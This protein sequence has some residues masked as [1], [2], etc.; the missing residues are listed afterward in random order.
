[1]SDGGSG[2]IVSGCDASVDSDGDGI[3]DDLEGTEDLDGDGTPNHL[4]TDSDGD[5]IDDATEAGDSPCALR[6]TD[7]DGTADWWD[8]DSDNDG[9]SDAD[10][11]GTYGTDPRNIDSDMDGVTDLGEV[12]GTMTDPLDPSSTIPADDFFVVLPW[13]GPRENRLLRF[14]TDIS[15]ADIYFLIDTTGSMGSP[16]SNVQ[17]SLSMLVSEIATRIPNA[18][19]GVGQFRDLPLGG[20]LT[21]Y[22]SP[23]DMAYA[24]EQDI[25]DNTGAVQ[26]AL[27]GLVAGGGAD[28]PESHVL[29]LFQT[30]Q[31][32]GG[33][34]S[35]GSD[36]WSLAAKNCT[37]IPDEM[38]RRRGYPCFRPG[39]LPI[40]VMVTDVDMHNDPTGQDAYTGITPPPYS[41]DQAMSALGSIG[42]RF[43]GVAVNGG[44]R[45]DM[46]EV[47]RRTGTVDGSGAPLVFDA[48][49]GTVSNSIVDGIGTL[50]GGVAQDVGTRTENVP[51]NPDEFDATQ[52]I[53]AITPVE[54]Y[55]EGV[56]GTGYDSFDETTFY[57]VIPGTQVEFDVDFYNDV[58]PPAA[59]AEIF[60]ARIIVVGNGVAD[61]D[62][63]EVYIIVPPDGGTIL[64]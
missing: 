28:G 64:I 55:R 31:P 24:N 6:D 43:I 1:M 11:V 36:S 38:G 30:A 49:G 35:D 40:I 21:G 10:E 32:L 9:L 61:L 26:T 58:R 22:G 14:G 37:P 59:A 18:Q 34:W 50:T 19:M 46:E 7:S 16:I 39:A 17:S 20:G 45:G 41:F 8:L 15:V 33:T 51:G 4:D 53:K 47:A 42:A 13:N 48:S 23:G 44:G 54:G 62:A 25:T 57:N 63:R 27:D 2:P 5:G 12:E 29:A 60:R 52:F 56:P 3:A